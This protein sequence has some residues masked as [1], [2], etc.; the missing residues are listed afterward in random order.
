MRRRPL[1]APPQYPA[2]DV[3]RED[4]RILGFKPEEGRMEPDLTDWQLRDRLVGKVLFSS[5]EARW[6][7]PNGLVV[8]L[9][10]EHVDTGSPD[11]EDD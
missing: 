8:D 6:Y 1:R 7:G 11:D 5:G 9:P 10:P 4:R 2:P 3:R